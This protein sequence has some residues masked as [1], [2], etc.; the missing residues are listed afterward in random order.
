MTTPM[1]ESIPRPAIL[2]PIDLHGVDARTLRTLVDIARLLDRNLLGVF[3][4]DQ[5]LQQ[6]A[7][8]PFSSEIILSSGRE[9]GLERRELSRRQ[10]RVSADIRHRL[11]DLA[12]RY[13]IGLSFEYGAG[14]RWHS[15]VQR[16]TPVDIF[17]PPRRP[18]RANFQSPVA[19][20][21]IPRLGLLL[22]G[23]QSDRHTIETAT[24]LIRAGLVRDIYLLCESAVGDE[25]LR[26][27]D[28]KGTR[29]CVQAGLQLNPQTVLALIRQSPCQ[30]L[31]VPRN[32]LHAIDTAQLDAA[33]D[34][35]SAEV[36]V[37]NGSPANRPLSP[38]G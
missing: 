17:F 23:D 25:A 21:A 5:R 10:S 20:M 9:R 12:R 36:M 24:G 29:I 22:Q 13:R 37:I 7:D 34:A 30:L 4:E 6:I 14:T 15:V 16:P 32:L 28:W 31:L 8:L 11:D 3:L 26:A 27:L 2:L 1:A 38:A 35:S 33:L 19:A 18:W